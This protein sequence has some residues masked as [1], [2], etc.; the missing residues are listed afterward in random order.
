MAEYKTIDDFFDGP[1]LIR[2]TKRVHIPAHILAEYNQKNGTEITELAVT[3]AKGTELTDEMFRSLMPSL[4][5]M[6][7]ETRNLPSN[8][9]VTGMKKIDIRNF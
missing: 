8:P 6:I 4:G 3:V 1:D 7:K 2:S 5:N 9:P